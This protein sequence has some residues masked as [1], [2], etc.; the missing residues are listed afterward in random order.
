MITLFGPPILSDRNNL[1]IFARS[2]A[3]PSLMSP[4]SLFS[5]SVKKD[6]TS[7]LSTGSFPLSDVGDSVEYV[8]DSVDLLLK[9]AG[10]LDVLLDLLDLV[11][12]VDL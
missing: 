2:A 5:S 3:L 8:G 12:L 9:V 11:D 1:V 10:C 7:S 4:K 6:T